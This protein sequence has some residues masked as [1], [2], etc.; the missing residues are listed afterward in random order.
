MNPVFCLICLLRCTVTCDM[1][2][3]QF[4]ARRECWHFTAACLR[5][6]SQ[7]FLTLG[8]SSSPTMSLKR[9][10]LRHQKLETQEVSGAQTHRPAHNVCHA[11]YSQ[12]ELLRL[13]MFPFKET[14]GASSVAVELEW[15]AKHSHTPLTS[16]RRD[17]RWGALTQHEFTSDR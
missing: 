12:S 13:F 6:W 10:C 8:C 3:L 17:S 15:L 14:W 1:L 5:R 7:F 4:A 2:C 11:R 16:S 9:C